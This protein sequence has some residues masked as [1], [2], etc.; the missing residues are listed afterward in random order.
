MAIF[1]VLAI[2]ILLTATIVIIQSNKKKETPTTSPPTTKPPTTKPPTTTPA[3]TTTPPPACTK[4]KY[5]TSCL[6]TCGDKFVDENE[7]KC[8]DTVPDGKYAD[9]KTLLT[10][11]GESETNKIVKDDMC[12]NTCNEFLHSSQD[13]TVEGECKST[14]DDYFTKDY[15]TETTFRKICLKASEWAEI[16]D[17]DNIKINDNFTRF[18]ITLNSNYSEPDIVS[19]GLGNTT[20]KEIVSI[21]FL[22]DDNNIIDNFIDL[23]MSSSG[24]LYA[25]VYKNKVQIFDELE[26]NS[27]PSIDFTDNITLPIKIRDSSYNEIKDFYFYGRDNI[28]PNKLTQ[29]IVIFTDNVRNWMFPFTI[30]K[31]LVNGNF[32]YSIQYFENI[33]N[34]ISISLYINK[35]EYLGISY[36]DQNTNVYSFSISITKLQNNEVVPSSAESIVDRY[37]FDVTYYFNNTPSEYVFRTA[38]NIIKDNNP[39]TDGIYDYEYLSV[40]PTFYLTSI[41]RLY[42]SGLTLDIKHKNNTTNNIILDV[43][44]TNIVSNIAVAS[45]IT[46]STIIPDN[47][48][49]RETEEIVYFATRDPNIPN[50][51]NINKFKYTSPQT[52]NSQVIRQ[53]AGLFTSGT[54]AALSSNIDG[55]ILTIGVHNGDKKNLYKYDDTT[56]TFSTIF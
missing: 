20:T 17:F 55:S 32:T 46:N 33:W 44:Q 27:L 53:I 24:S 26:N 51:L 13:E 8:Y 49:P 22:K 11:C 19:F 31:T 4:Y 10:S 54:Y 47:N 21:G 41:L 23:K 9:G 38:Y 45:K 28:T 52:I 5:N 16:F 40:K 36:V 14:C 3:P 29:G 30:N 6:D 12:V 43:K 42:N 2:V 15:I 48:N 34:P 7:K 1:I 39:G 50:V 56:N 18:L 25:A 37:E 35:P